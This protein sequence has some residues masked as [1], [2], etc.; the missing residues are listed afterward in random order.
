MNKIKE[1]ISNKLMKLK[2]RPKCQSSKTRYNN[3]TQ[4]SFTFKSSLFTEK[5]KSLIEKLISQ[6]I[7]PDNSFSKEEIKEKEKKEKN[8]NIKNKTS[9]KIKNKNFK[10]TNNS[11]IIN[12]RIFQDINNIKK[13]VFCKK[14][15][16]SINNSTYSNINYRNNLRNYENASITNCRIEP[17]KRRKYKF[18]IMNNNNNTI[19]KKKF[20]FNG[21]VNNNIRN[22]SVKSNLNS[23]KKNNSS[24]CLYERKKLNGSVKIG[25]HFNKRNSVN[26][27]NILNVITV[28]TVNLKNRI[29]NINNMKLVENKNKS[30]ILVNQKYRNAIYNHH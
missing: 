8:S 4:M 15:L 21:I 6:S 1:D 3:P 12:K 17:I 29:S 2:K 19:D 30:K 25:N 28:N 24:K 5:N 18:K 23:N 10:T 22:N 13:K 20:I 14:I 27:K 9:V 11:K 7:S 26:K 16:K